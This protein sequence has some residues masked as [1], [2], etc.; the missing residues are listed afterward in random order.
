M[1]RE[2]VERVL[3]AEEVAR[4]RIEEARKKAAAIRQEADQAASTLLA[5]A[6]EKSVR[7]SKARLDVARSA[8]AALMDQARQESLAGAGEAEAQAAQTTASLVDDIVAM[9]TG[10]VDTR[11]ATTG[12]VP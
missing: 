12:Q 4:A 6:R 7:D 9:M 3:G 1:M 5:A 11:Q 8:A 2:V 10:Q